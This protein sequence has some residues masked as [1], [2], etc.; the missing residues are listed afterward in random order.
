MFDV[1]LD[2]C[3]GGNELRSVGAPDADDVAKII[4]RRLA[5]ATHNADHVDLNPAQRLAI[6]HLREQLLRLVRKRTA[7][8]G[9]ID[10]IRFSPLGVG[11]QPTPVQQEI[12]YELTQGF[13]EQVYA[14][15]SALASVHG[16]IRLFPDLSEAPIR[17]ND[18]FLSWWELVS[19]EG[20]M[21]SESIAHLQAAR[22]FRTIF[23]HPQMWPL[24]D[25]R[26]VAAGDE[27][28]VVLY[29]SESSK[30]TIPPGS[31]RSQ[32][33]TVWEFYAPGM[34]AVIWSFEQLCL[35]TFGPIFSWYPSDEE[36]VACLWEPDGAGSTIGDEAAM[37]LRDALSDD[38][39]D[40]HVRRR[41]SPSIIRDL[42]HYIESMREIRQVAQRMERPS[43]IRTGIPAAKASTL[44]SLPF[45]ESRREEAS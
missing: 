40:P 44:L 30:G 9:H 20:W 23:M 15:L 45:A 33:P 22:N 8:Y 4:A 10:S 21:L 38:S 12:A 42:D 34:D 18:R 11:R 32:E 35:A 1:V 43:A 37:S 27:I 5:Y 26:T 31:E 14:T 28:D 17:S 19:A 36:A 6:Q 29:G 7:Y 2:S 41:L 16:R 25:W 24:F 3:V 13:F 39:F